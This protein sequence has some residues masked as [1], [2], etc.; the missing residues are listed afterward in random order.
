[1]DFTREPIVETVITPRDGYKLVVRSS[2]NHGHEEFMVDA[3]E[4][5]SFG[6]TCFFRSLERPK[7]FIVPASDYEI[8]ELRESRLPLKAAP[9]EGVIKA[10]PAPKAAPREPERREP[11]PQLKEP[12]VEPEAIPS[13]PSVEESEPVSGEKRSDKRRDRKKN[14]RRR[15]GGREEGENGAPGAPEKKESP[16]VGSEP[17]TPAPKESTVTSLLPPPTT[18]IRDDL[19]RLRATE[20]YK[21]A[22][23]VK[24]EA[25]PVEEEGDDDS[26]VVPL[27]LR[28]EEDLPRFVE[29]KVKKP[30]QAEDTYKATPEPLEE[31]SFWG[32]RPSKSTPA[33]PPVG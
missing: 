30:S 26:P 1:M 5:V 27:S 2:K 23:Y 29:E 22:F 21:G 11:V 28:G 18:L 19:K 12:V 20:E 9:M 24:E 14:L 17:T 31:E 4:V 7:V 6:S 15:R 10:A 16:V 33:N 32:V 8:F 25:S 13:E 3:L